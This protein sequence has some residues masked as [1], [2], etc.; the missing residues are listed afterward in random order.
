MAIN[1][2]QQTRK[3]RR[4]SPGG[5]DI[6]IAHLPDDL[7]TG[8]AEYLPKTSV[9]LLAATFSKSEFTKQPSE[10]SK[11]IVCSLKESSNEEPWEEIDFLDIE[12]SLRLK[13]TDDDI[14]GILTC[15][16]AVNKLKRL[17]LTH[18][19]RIGGC[20][21]EPLRGS[22]VLEQLDLSLVCQQECSVTMCV[23][24]GT[25]MRSPCISEK[26]VLPIL[27]SIV[28]K[29]CSLL[30][31]L[32]FP[33]KWLDA[34]CQAFHQFLERYDGFLKRRGICCFCCDEISRDDMLSKTGDKYGLQIH[35]CYNCMRTLCSDCAEY[36]MDL[37][38][39]CNKT[40]CED[41]VEILFCETCYRESCTGCGDVKYCDACD[42]HYCDSCGH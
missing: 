7:L 37:C 4:T 26:D 39:Q 36:E 31:Q 16:D 12:K 35:T 23:M 11:A 25:R 13:L 17:K 21:L 9:A 8:V 3:R 14:E 27:D 15:I 32:Q 22:L 28:D 2:R 30:Q 40:Y 38:R 6:S 18:C 29:E 41:C 33:Q 20:G 19:F 42:L 10:T 34:K 24:D 1:T 5:L